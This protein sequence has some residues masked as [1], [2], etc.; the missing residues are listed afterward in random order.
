[1][2][3]SAPAGSGSK[4]LPAMP[5]ARSARPA[6][7]NLSRAAAMVGAISRTRPRIPG[8][9]VRIAASK[10]PSPPPTS[11]MSVKR[12]QSNRSAIWVAKTWNRHR[13]WAS[14]EVRSTGLGIEVGPEVATVSPRVGGC[15][16][17]DRVEQL[18][19]GQFGAA[20]RAIDIEQ[21]LD[22]L[23]ESERS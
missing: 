22:S 6:A 13:I 15:A 9:A 19:E 4:K 11:T 21:D 18:D 8:W 12:P 23:G 1:M 17:G 16:G 14:N 10:F 7:E 3:V 20:A 5:V 2:Y